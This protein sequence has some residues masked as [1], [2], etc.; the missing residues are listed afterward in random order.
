MAAWFNAYKIFVR[1]NAGIVGANHTR[2]MDVCV[3]SVFVLSYMG[4]GLATGMI[5]RPRSPTNCVQNPQ[6]Q[7]ISDEK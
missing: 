1:S 7:I 2:G 4:I 5:I 6:F 3:T